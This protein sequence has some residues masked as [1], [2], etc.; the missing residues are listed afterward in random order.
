MVN[1][2]PTPLPTTRDAWNRAFRTFV[3]GLWVDVSAA[4]V[5]VLATALTDVRWTKEYWIGLG[6]MLAKTVAIAAMSYVYRRLRPPP[7]Q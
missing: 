3:Q 6:L 5:L 1:P 7:S 4:L 2:L